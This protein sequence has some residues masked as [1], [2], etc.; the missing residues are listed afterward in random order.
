MENKNNEQEVDLLDIITLCFSKINSFF[1]SLLSLGAWFLRFVYRHKK[2]F[3]AVLVA[4]VAFSFFWSRP[5]NRK[6]RM[7]AEIRIN[8]MDAF[9][10][11]DMVDVIDHYCKNSDQGLM[12]GMLGLDENMC[13][14]I[15]RAQSF[16]Y[17]DKLKDGTPDEIC[18]EDKYIADT[19]KRQMEDRL[20]IRVVVTDTTDMNKI[21]NGL[22]YYFDNNPMVSR[23]NKERMAQLDGKINSLTNESVLL[24]SLRRNEYFH[25]SNP[26][27]KLGGSLFL[28]EKDKQ[29]YHGELLNLENTM[30]KVRYEKA[31]SATSVNFVSDF[32]M[33]K[34]VNNLFIT[35]IISFSLMFLTAFLILLVLEK[36]KQIVD[37][38]E[39][40]DD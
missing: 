25:K 33:V 19:T 24:D 27:V 16:F 32:F 18:Y 20:L 17:V 6:Y 15:K 29:L 39:K 26:D 35:F 30:N 5:E 11:H 9:F 22:Q 31:V 1:H 37:F 14:R 21:K 40:N 4:A 10:Y 8:V 34:I 7:E 28:T 36:K 12:C 23:M 38:L 13:N 2:A 3:L